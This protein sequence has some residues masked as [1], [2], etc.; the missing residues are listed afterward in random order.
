[1]TDTDLVEYLI[2][3]PY[4]DEIAADGWRLD[5]DGM[6]AI[7]DGPGLGLTISHDALRKYG[8]EPGGLTWLV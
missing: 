5:A 1:L 8:R 4:V 6:L 3:S 2:G 7:P